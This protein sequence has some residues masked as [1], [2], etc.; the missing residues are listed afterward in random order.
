[1]KH[2]VD[3]MSTIETL[4]QSHAH[5]P[6]PEPRLSLRT[7]LAF[8]VGDVGPAIAGT[9]RSFF[10][11]F[12]LANVAGLGPL[13]AGTLV[14]VARLWD[15]LTDPLVGWFI[16]RTHSR[17]GR[18]RPWLL[19]GAVP[20]GISFALLWTIPPLD[21]TGTLLYMLVAV[22]LFSTAMTTITI[23]HAALTTELS[24]NYDERT[25]LTAYRFGFGIG[26]GLL[27]GLLFATLSTAFCADPTQCL[28]AERQT[29]YFVAGLS[30]VAALI[31]P[32]L[33]CFVGV[34]ERARPT[35]RIPLRHLATQ[36]RE[37]W[38]LSA[39]RWVVGI[40]LCSLLAAQ[41]TAAVLPFYLTFW[42]QREDLFG[43]LFPGVQV[44][45]FL[46]LLLWNT[47]SKRLGKRVVYVIGMLSWV[48]I[49][50]ML[51]FL[52]T[53][54]VT[55]GVVLGTLAGAGLAA[56]YLLPWSMLADVVDLDELQSGQ[57]REGICY[58]LAVLLHKLGIAS[59][60][61]LMGVLLE[62]QGFDAELAVGSQPDSALLALRW[63]I[64]P[65]PAVL[66]LLGIVCVWRY[67][68]TRS[69]HAAIRAQL[70]NRTSDETIP[71]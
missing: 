41:L 55:L 68:I 12:F 34:R 56:C 19:Y 54:Q 63:L 1:V 49:Q 59:G 23:P 39:F 30:L 37:L 2:K 31:I 16:D 3:T 61:L 4:S 22:I 53:H 46:F 60:L 29:G 14:W 36:I 8:G 13:A 9:A 64:G 25:T 20:F 43:L 7:K 33:I 57:R 26:S 42:M 18:L 40:Q 38:A 52:Q 28:P 10:L 5:H 70:T 71:D 66:V 58:G 67:N 15:A 45:S 21:D 24:R 69:Q 51:F 62:W 50:A 6:D 65:I 44:A 11:F 32:T 17:Y 27:G 48:V 47:V 35:P